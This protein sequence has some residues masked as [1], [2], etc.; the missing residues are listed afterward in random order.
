MK[1]KSVVVLLLA[2]LL[3]LPCLAQ[4]EESAA[5]TL[6]M[7]EVKEWTERY[8]ERA[9]AAKPLNKPKESLTSDGYEFIYEFATIYAEKATLKADTVINAVVITSPEE[10]GPRGVCVD[11]TMQVV[12]S[13]FYHENPD[14]LG[15]RDSAVIYLVDLLPDILQWGEVQRDG[16]RVET[17]QYAV[18]E[19]LTTGG[20]GYTDAGVI[21]TMQDGTVSAIR[22]YGADSRIGLDTVYGMRSYL[23]SAA[24]AA[25]YQQVPFSY[26]GAS[27]DKFHGGDLVFSGIDFAALTPEDALALLG[28]PIGDEWM[29][30]GDNGFTRMMS[31]PS[32]EITFEYDLNRENPAIYM[33]LLVTDGIEGPRAVRIGDTFPQVFNRFRNGEGEFDGMSRET[34]YGDEMTG[35]FGTAEYGMDASA[36][37]RYGLVLEDGRHVVLH[38]TFTAMELSEVMLY[39][40]P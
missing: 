21:F 10:E 20:D 12:L 30:D 32:C 34:L 38:M 19:Q 27:L 14:L 36:S 1:M 35:E 26:D 25:E 24:V 3:A 31:F 39:M 13:A 29:E 40:V 23:Q 28:D 17:I 16:Q 4:A 33:L 8:R 18:H 9:L 15:T 5:D 6:T 37:L 7:T 2:L 22:V 11:D